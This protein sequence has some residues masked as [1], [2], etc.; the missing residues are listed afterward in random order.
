MSIARDV[1]K[2]INIEDLMKNGWTSSSGT[3]QSMVS[4][5]SDDIQRRIARAR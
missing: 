4:N 5:A 2:T 3:M 1:S